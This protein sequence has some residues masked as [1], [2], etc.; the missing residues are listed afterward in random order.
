MVKVRAF[1]SK[2][3]RSSLGIGS[4]AFNICIWKILSIFNILTTIFKKFFRFDYW[5]VDNKVALIRSISNYSLNLSIFNFILSMVS[6]SLSRWSEVGMPL[7]SF[8][9]SLCIFMDLTGSNNFLRFAAVITYSSVLY[10]L[11][12]QV[13]IKKR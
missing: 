1:N 7:D 12:M 5:R 6:H 10:W 11:K 4:R 2:I 3:S 13:A 8:A 9:M